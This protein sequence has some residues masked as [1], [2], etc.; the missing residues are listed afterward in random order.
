MAQPW[1]VHSGSPGSP[2]SPCSSCRSCWSVAYPLAA[3]ARP[4]LRTTRCQ[5]GRSALE[6]LLLR[7]MSWAAI[8]TRRSPRNCTLALPAFPTTCAPPHQYRSAL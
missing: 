2:G 8:S 4:E 5:Q 7:R 1:E 6:D 3:G